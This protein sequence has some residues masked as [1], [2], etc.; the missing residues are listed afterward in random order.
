MPNPQEAYTAAIVR[1]CDD[2]LARVKA[3]RDARHLAVSMVAVF[4]GQ[5]R[6]PYRA[7]SAVYAKARKAYDKAVRTSEAQRTKD[8]A[9]AMATFQV[10]DPPEVATRKVQRVATC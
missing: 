2:H 8:E 1:A 4:G 3:A 7:R 10:C 6:R 9:I 5:D